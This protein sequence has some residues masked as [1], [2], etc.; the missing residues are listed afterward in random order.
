MNPMASDSQSNGT[1]LESEYVHSMYRIMLYDGIRILQMIIGITGNAL[2]LH[3]IRNLKVLKNEHVLM[4]YTAMSD[5]FSGCIVPLG[6]VTTIGSSKNR[7]RYWKA[8]CVW[9]DYLHLT[10]NAYSLICYFIIAVDR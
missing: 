6:T 5:I 8:L 4:V 3:I 1:N 7:P 2:T 9:T 10:A